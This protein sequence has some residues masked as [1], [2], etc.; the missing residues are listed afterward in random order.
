MV[1]R[2]AAGVVMRR[3]L[4]GIGACAVQSAQ[5]GESRLDQST[6]SP[7]EPPGP[8]PRGSIDEAGDTVRP[9]CA[10]TGPFP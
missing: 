9:L 3:E 6:T 2:G 10:T 5:M 8:L 4:L 7:R 1:L